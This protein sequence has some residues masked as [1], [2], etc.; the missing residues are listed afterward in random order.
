VVRRRRSLVI[1]AAVQGTILFLVGLGLLIHEATLPAADVSWPRLV[2]FAG[3]MGGPF[4]AW[5]DEARKAGAM[6]RP[7]PPDEEG[8]P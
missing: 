3:M 5:A 4:A 7:P 2:V 1:P 8:E 6:L